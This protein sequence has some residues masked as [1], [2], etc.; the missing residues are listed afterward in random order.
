MGTEDKW[1]YVAQEFAW[2]E[3]RDDCF[4][5]ASTSQTS[6]IVDFIA[7]K[8]GWTTFGADCVKAYYQSEQ[9]EKV[10][11]KPPA[12]YIELLRLA[13]RPTDIVWKLHKMLPG[14]RLGGRGWVE[15][16][17]KRL[18]GEGFVRCEALPQFFRRPED[19]I[20]IEVHMDDFH[21]TG[22][23]IATAG[24]VESLRKVFDLKATEVFST[25]R[26]SHLRRDR[27]RKHGATYLRAN[28]VHVDKLV[29]LYQMRDAKIAK[30]PSMADKR[31][32]DAEILD[33]DEQAKYRTGVGILL[34]L[35]VDRWDVKRDTEL[36]ARH[37]ATPSVHDR[38][39]M[40]KVI[41][42]LKGT[43]TFGHKLELN[44][45]AVA[46]LVYLNMHSDTNFAPDDG[47]R[48]AMTC[49]IFDAD[50][51]KLHGFGKRQGVQSTS[52]GEAEFYGATS[53]VMDGK[54]LWHV[55]EWM[56]Y[57]VVASLHV[58]S[59]AA[60]GMLLRD[61]VGAVKHL[62]V[63]S[64]WV[65][66][67]R[68]HGLKIKKVTGADNVADVC[69]K[70][71]PESR[72]LQLRTMAG[73]VDCAHIDK[74]S[75]H[76]A[77][78]IEMVF[79]SNEAAGGASTAANSAAWSGALR[80]LTAAAALAQGQAATDIAKVEAHYDDEFY[81]WSLCADSAVLFVVAALLVTT[82]TVTTIVLL[83]WRLMAAWT[84]EVKLEKKLCLLYTS[85]AADE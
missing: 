54:L 44:A 81:A 50:G 8:E 68:H 27:L 45:S 64:L 59:A 19:G 39:R 15:T 70:D 80:L 23:Q 11:V 41:R 71:H 56:G 83:Q 36:L 25:G 57:T 52:S 21:G 65:Q 67:E 24:C 53:V 5:A 28:P 85:D 34:Y 10:C 20:V 17:T 74:Y 3:Q 51:C 29:D 1:R 49:G 46:G 55:L 37:L 16:A 77:N 12:E 79:G 66:Q 43:R 4:A 13:G 82:V 62:D 72:F 47:T 22:E 32:E 33:P 61:G 7:L 42:Y 58:D 84:R 18:E 76:E 30:T 63:R 38:K 73:M 9:L 6:R 78:A 35:A 26:Y 14:Q 31:D 69:T 60:K 2:Q 40:V 75:E 48:R